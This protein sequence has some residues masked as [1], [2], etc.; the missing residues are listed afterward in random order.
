MSLHGRLAESLEKVKWHGHYFSCLCVFHD[1]TNTPAMMV[2]PDRYYCKSCHASGTLT[3]LEKKLHGVNITKGKVHI[4]SPRILPRWSNWMRKYENIANLAADAHANLLRFKNNRHFFRKRHIEEY[5][6][7][8]MFGCL[9]GWL[10]F[11]VFDKNKEIIDLVARAT[12]GKGD[13]KYV[14]YPVAESNSRSLYVPD[15][16]LVLKSDEIYAVYGIIDSWALYSLKLPVITGITGKSLSSENIKPLNK[17]TNII[18][19]QYEEAEAYKLA[20]EL[21]WRSRVL[22]INWPSGTKDTDEI[23][24]SLGEKTL[25]KLIMESK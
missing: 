18:P 23:R 13:T 1:N 11:P 4:D 19:D 15:W 3:Y 22:R 20:Y 9:D 5:I 21:G 25:K 6:D 12:P 16:D 17:L 8:G 10:I 24:T 7:V 2:Y 14:V